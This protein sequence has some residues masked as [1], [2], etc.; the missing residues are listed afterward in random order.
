MSSD[1]NGIYQRSMFEDISIVKQEIPLND[2]YRLLSQKLPWVELARIADQ[3]RSERVNIHVGSK[4]NM[5]LHLGILV[6]QSMRGW[7]DRDAEDMVKYH[8]GVRILCGIADSM[9]TK[10]HTS[11]TKF[12][13]Q[14]G[15]RG[16]QELNEAIIKAALD[17]GF[18]SH[19][20]CASDTTVQEAPVAY[21]TE[22]GHMKNIASN[23]R[24]IAGKI[25][26]GICDKV[27]QL[28]EK[29]KKIF[30]KIRLFTRGKK[31]QVIE[32]KKV[33][34]KEL[35]NVVSKMAKAVSKEL[36]SMETAAKE[37]YQESIGLYQRMLEQIKQWLATGYH[38][39]NKI[40]SLWHNDARAI[41][42]EKAKH[43]VE[44]GVEW[45]ISRLSRGY[46]IAKISSK[47]GGGIDSSVVEENLDHFLRVTG[48][49]PQRYVYD[50]GA[51][52]EFNHEKLKEKKIKEDCIYLKGK[53]RIYSRVFQR[54][55][56]GIAKARSLTEASISVIKG[57]RYGFTKPRA[58]TVQSCETKGHF[59]VLGS[60]LSR[61]MNDIMSPRG[62]E[63]WSW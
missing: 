36:D 51:D 63:V 3:H 52:S 37:K 35:H 2:M 17:A 15:P 41:T 38:P 22:V 46:V 23:L 54:Q 48:K 18:T 50:R 27:S 40:I 26:R 55:S 20:L 4:L 8:T 16:V 32:K 61:F 12:R 47:L 44:F 10:D 53:K 9:E 56:H 6:L 43:S 14:V 49:V 42:K 60:N 58:K 1:L 59:A 34:S 29:A 25:H 62:M 7:T 31:E 13:N 28:G 39:K 19:R 24:D 30:T 5:R 45:I 11:I 21:P 57:R 33:L